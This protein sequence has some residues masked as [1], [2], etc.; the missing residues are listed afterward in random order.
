MTGVGLGSDWGPRSATERPLTTGVGPRTWEWCTQTLVSCRLTFVRWLL[1]FVRWLLTPVR[2]LLTFVCCRPPFPYC[3]PTIV[4]CRPPFHCCPRTKA[5]VSWFAL[6]ESTHKPRSP[7][8]GPRQPRAWPHLRQLGPQPRQIGSKPGAPRTQ[9]RRLRPD[10][11]RMRRQTT[12]PTPYLCRTRPD[13]PEC[14]G[15]HRPWLFALVPGTFRSVVRTASWYLLPLYG[16]S[17]LGNGER[18]SVNTPIHSTRFRRQ[19]APAY[20]QH[21][22][23]P[24]CACISKE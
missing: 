8:P 16:R 10:P 23:C 20:G 11:A 7:R 3:R 1:A 13:G 18:S 2:W 5:L 19:G 22:C 6:A 12:S 4:H 24:A 17:P 9:M 21:R 15:S 14:V